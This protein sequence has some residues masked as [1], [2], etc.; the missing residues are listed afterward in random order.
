LVELHLPVMERE[1]L[2]YLAC[3]GDGVY[4]DAT[5]G[6]GGHAEAIAAPFHRQV[7]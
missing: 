5:L 7:A 4:V 1:V 3:R 2:Q 6:D